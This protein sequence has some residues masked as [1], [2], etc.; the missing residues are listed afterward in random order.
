MAEL[1]PL[2]QLNAVRRARSA[3]KASACSRHVV[4]FDFQSSREASGLISSFHDLN[5]I[6][7]SEGKLPAGWVLE[8]VVARMQHGA[9][10]RDDW[11]ARFRVDAHFKDGDAAFV[12][13]LIN[14]LK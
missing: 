10:G 13:S 6:L 2:T 5:P 7:P 14:L 4:E 9:P 1:G 12:R 11:V 3:D 8:T